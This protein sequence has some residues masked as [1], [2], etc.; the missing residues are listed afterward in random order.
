MDACLHEISKR[1][2][3]ARKKQDKCLTKVCEKI[4]TDVK[5]LLHGKTGDEDSL[6]GT[7]KPKED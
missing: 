5:G 3:S 1:K 2:N 4:M 6:S 7:N